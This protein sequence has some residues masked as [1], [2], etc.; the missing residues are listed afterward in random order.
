[1]QNKQNFLDPKTVL[2]IVLSAVVF[3]LYS[4]YLTKKYPQNTEQPIANEERTAEAKNEREVIKADSQ[5]KIIAPTAES[6]NSISKV[7]QTLEF[8]SEVFSFKISSKGM[9]LKDVKLG[10][11]RDRENKFKQIGFM[12]DQLP[13]ET[14]LIGRREPLYF[15]LEQVSEKKFKGVALYKGIKITKVYNIEPTLYKIN[16]IV[17]VDKLVDSF[18][19]IKTFILSAVHKPE[20]TG[21]LPG[22]RFDL[23][24]LFVSLG[25]SDDRENIDS[26]TDLNEKYTRVSAASLGDQ[27]FTQAFVDRSKMLPDLSI[28]SS[29]YNR[30][31]DDEYAKALVTVNYPVISRTQSYEVQYISYLGPKVLEVLEA[32]DVQ[33]LGAID[34]GFFSFLARP[35]LSLLKWFHALA[36]NWGAAIVLLTILVRF[37]MLPLHLVSHK[38]MKNMQKVGPLLKELKAKY[39][40]DPQMQNQKMIEL[41]KTNKINPLSGCLPML[42][43][44]PVFFA[45]YQVI[46]QSIE[47]YQAPFALWVGDLSLSDPYYVLPILMGITMFFQMKMTP[48]TMDPTQAK[49]MMFMP[50]M[51]TFIMLSLPSGLTL[52]FF[53]SGLFGIIQQ[54]LMR[55]R[56]PQATAQVVTTN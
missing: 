11:Y 6:Q 53:I 28:V 15:N 33:L 10:K 16:V 14:S 9:G 34:Y 45:L 40:D 22:S 39:K 2:A 47:L 50:I 26:S 31:A 3:M 55:D 12:S 48:S 30:D 51:F 41:Y 29:V 4:S 36:G 25:S 44:I 42:L 54:Y 8:N 13:F 20:S 43:Q 5:K 32:V 52:Y 27:Y 56:S 7:E 23:Y 18:D 24:Q 19:G 38:S 1:M 46:G 21:F 49:I 17:T 37:L 35:L